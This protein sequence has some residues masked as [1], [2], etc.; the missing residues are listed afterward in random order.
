VVGEIRDQVLEAAMSFLGEVTRGY[1]LKEK[2][3]R[4]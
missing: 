2:K 1:V 4:G 3:R